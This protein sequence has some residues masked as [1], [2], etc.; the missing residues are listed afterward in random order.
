VAVLPTQEMVRFGLF[1][2][3]L[4]AVQL[5]RNGTRIRLPQQPLQL[6]SVLIESP[7]EIVTR[8]QLRQRLWPSDV[9]IDFDHGLNKSIQKLRDALGDS[10]DSPRYIETIP[11]V[12]YRFIAPVRNGTWSWEPETD[13]EILQPAQPPAVNPVPP[14]A[15]IAGNRGA[16][17]LLFAA[18]GLTICA[19]IGVAVYFSFRAHPAV[20]EYTQLTDFTDS[21][22]TPALSPDGHI[23][24]FI[25]GDSSFMSAG[26]IY[27]KML[28]DGE[29][30]PLTNDARVKY[31]LAF[32]PDGSQIAYTVLENPIFATYTISVLGGDSHL[33]LSNA[34][35]LTWLD[36]HHFLFSKIR[37]GLHLGIVTATVTG[38]DFRELYYPPHERAMAHYSF[39]SP[40]RRSALV[41]EM[42]GQGEWSL[43]QLIS[44]EDR[45]QPRPVGPDGACTAAGWSPDGSWMYFV[46]TVQG[47]SHLWRQGSPN[48]RPEQ[49]TFGPSEEGGLAVE[50][51][52]HSIITSIG[53]HESSIWIHDAAGER[54]LS[55]EGE[56][57]AG[58]SPPSFGPGDKTL[59]YLLRHKGANAGPE[60]WRL[61]LDTGKSEAVFPGTSIDSY[62]VSP[63]GKQV[64]YASVGR[65]GISQLWLAPTDRS[66]PARQIG[67]SGET[68]PHFGPRGQILFRLAE[69]NFNYLE[70][71]NQEGSGRSK[72]F[73]YPIIEVQG[74]SPGRRWLMANVTYPEGNSMLPMIVA[75]PLD[76]GYPRR[77]CAGYCFPVWSSSGRFLFVPVEASSPSSPGRSLAIP[78]GRGETLPELPPGGIQPLAEPSVVPGAQSISRAELVPSMDPSHYAYVNR[79]VHRNLYRISLP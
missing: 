20:V 60:L 73:P 30:R 38:G 50:Q 65:D 27:V 21:A 69:G 10:A 4:K 3:D 62:D 15:A 42:N 54:S 9:F 24:A 70:Q 68:L 67:H 64:V 45:A 40:D 59:Y 56:I 52:G 51:D 75:I 76:G 63:D 8:E 71:M 74:I 61:T 78:V 1:E 53:V 55:S 14:P 11:R 32:S 44:L 18:G 31:N 41:V 33:L 12:G 34:A 72:I 77:I 79:T 46:A 57:A 23:L 39:A 16:R 22:T 28:P 36:P 13:I 2:L 19:A 29:A 35:G 6:L 47:Q 17:W 58:L 25:R 48:G 26:Q 43:C 49:I 66:F 37:S 5:T 7:G